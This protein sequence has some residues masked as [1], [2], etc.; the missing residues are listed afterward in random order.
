MVY[1]KCDKSQAI[2]M[3]T[4]ICIKL[5]LEKFEKFPVREKI[6]LSFLS[7]VLSLALLPQENLVKNKCAF[8]F[9]QGTKV[10]IL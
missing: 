8:L 3:F 7:R 9:T 6:F 1:V 2:C 5:D 4:I 10:L